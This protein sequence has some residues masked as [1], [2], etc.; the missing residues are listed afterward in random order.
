LRYLQASCLP[1][2]KRD[3]PR[4]IMNGKKVF[5]FVLDAVTKSVTALLQQ[6]QMRQEDIGDKQPG[7]N[8]Q[9]TTTR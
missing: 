7:D 2:E 6:A 1:S 4:F 8:N 5:D 3:R 9:V